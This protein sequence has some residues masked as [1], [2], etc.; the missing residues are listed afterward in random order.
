MIE[1]I[2]VRRCSICKK[3]SCDGKEYRVRIVYEYYEKVD[4]EA[5]VCSSMVFKIPDGT[6]L[7]K[8]VCAVGYSNSFPAIPI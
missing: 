5:I 6:Y 1:E 8:V 4:M 2:I 3:P 7:H